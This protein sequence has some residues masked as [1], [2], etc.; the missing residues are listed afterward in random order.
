MLGVARYCLGVTL[1]LSTVGCSADP[2]PISLAGRAALGSAEALG[3]RPLLGWNSFDVL[4]TSRPGY[5]QTWLTEGHLR[6]ASDAMQQHLQ[7]AGYEYINIDSGWSATLQWTTNSHDEYGVFEPDPERFPHGMDGMAA[8]VHAKGQ[9]L[10]IY[11][12]VGIPSEAYN[13]N[14]PIRGTNCRT[15][16][17]ARQPLTAVPNGWFGQYEIDWNNPCSQIYYNEQADK[18][19]AWGI[20]LVKVDGTTADNGPDI[21]AWQKALAQTGRPIWL[22]VSSWPVPLSLA[23]EIR[24]AGQGVRV[25]TDID[26]YCST[27]TTWT[28]S[29][30]QRWI[31]LPNWLPYVGPGHFPDLDSMP[32]SN[33]T[34]AGV[35]D[36]LNDAE[37]QS[38]MTFWSMASSPLWVGGDIWFM[39]AKAQEILTNPEVIAVDQA[40]VMPTRVAA[41]D[42]QIWKKPLPDGSQAVAVY[43]MSGSTA[44]ITVSFADLG[45]SGD[46]SVRDVVSRGDLGVFT[47]NWTAANV[48]AHGSRLVKV[49][50]LSAGSIAGYTFCAGEYQNCVLSGT[51]DVA[52]GAQGSYLFRSGMS[53]TIGCWNSTFGGADPAYGA[54]KGCYVRPQGGGGPASFTYCASESQNC[55]PSGVVDVA[56]GAVGSFVFKSG[57]SG[58]FA[59]ALATFGSDPA[60]G[61]NKSCYTRPSGG[62]VAYEA[63]SASLGGAAKVADCSG[64]SGGKKVGYVGNGSGNRVTFAQIDAGWTGDHQLIIHAAS[65][66][67]RRASVSVN[68]GAA[69]VAAVQSGDWNRPATVTVTVP[70]NRGLNSITLGNDGEYAP[71]IDRI[72]VR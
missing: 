17:I 53:G 9:K 16:D 71:D 4:A 65:A 59:C 5:G 60:Y 69:I 39:D 48:P 55:S 47:G 26:C 29:T 52:Y 64:C 63:E 45:L 14:F 19:A 50:A 46:A 44:S 21:I 34:G 56:Y 8:Y 38:V 37:R 18:F 6:D 10:G 36:G 58:A 12:V 54:T 23:Q 66:D 68:G 11:S 40:A 57:V 7:A 15:Q 27:L 30:N 42:L 70:L 62:G 51:M 49:A 67:A 22:T 43:N 3:T 2:A 1:A 61:W 41:G 31:D 24:H 25:D 32:I 72:V 20:D 28:A 13:G 35:Q 33:N